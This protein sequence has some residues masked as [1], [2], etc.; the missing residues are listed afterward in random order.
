MSLYWNFNPLGITGALTPV[1]GVRGVFVSSGSVP[2]SSAM[3]VTGGTVANGYPGN[4]LYVYSRGKAIEQTVAS[5]GR[6]YVCSGGA[7]GGITALFSGRL[8]VSSGGV[9]SNTTVI[10]N[11]TIIVSSGAVAVNITVDSGGIV[12]CY[13]GASALNVDWTPC[14]GFVQPN[15]SQEEQRR[16]QLI[17]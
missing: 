9:A 16:H 17:R 7:A 5:G 6:M 8:D 10:S 4:R 2:V 3:T 15:L 12:S 1:S 11:G 14:V 13:T